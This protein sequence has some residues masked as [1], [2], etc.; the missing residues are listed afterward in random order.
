M[1]RGIVGSNV[2]VFDVAAGPS[3]PSTRTQ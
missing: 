3:G 2:W 1:A